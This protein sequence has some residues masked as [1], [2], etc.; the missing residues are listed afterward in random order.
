MT[1]A[2]SARVRTARAGLEHVMGDIDATSTQRKRATDGLAR[3]DRMLAQGGVAR[4]AAMS[5]ISRKAWG[6]APARSDRMERTQGSYTRITVH[7]SADVDPPVLDGS[8]SKTFAAMREMQ[9]AH[10]N[11]RTFGDIGYHFV[12]DPYGRVLEGRELAYQ[13]AH[14]NGDNN[15]SN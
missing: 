14:A 2:L 3:A 5:V 6:A 9:K 12:I 15:V 4:T 1:Q 7:H 10:M 13:G 8:S 11:G